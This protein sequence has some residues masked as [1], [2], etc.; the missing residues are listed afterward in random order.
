[1][2]IALAPQCDVA[3]PPL[4]VGGLVPLTTTDYPGQLAAVVFC[5]GCPWQCGYCQNTHLIPAVDQTDLPWENV[6]AFLQRRRGL[7]DAVVFSGGEPTLQPGLEAAMLEAKDMGFLIGLHTA[8]TYPERLKNLLPLLDWVGMDIKAPFDLYQRITHVPGSGAK[9]LASTK[10]VLASGVACEFRTTVHPAL[11]S[12]EDLRTLA[13]ELAGMGAKN[14]VLQEFRPEGCADESL[15]AQSARGY[16]T[17]ELLAE[18]GTMFE[19]F[20]VRRS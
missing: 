19:N 12:H 7:L 5:Q 6:R 11:L 2:K 9:A 15:C 10:H 4:R 16:L 14:F 8:G 13:H 1:V 20:S 17:P 18:I 3:E